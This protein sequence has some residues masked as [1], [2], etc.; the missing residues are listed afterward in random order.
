MSS[1]NINMGQ[2]PWLL[3]IMVTSSQETKMN[4]AFDTSKWIDQNK[5]SWMASTMFQLVVL[6]QCL[7]GLFDT[8]K[9]LKSFS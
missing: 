2:N 1:H 3:S 5:K 4:R 9:K 8:L 7:L 6:I